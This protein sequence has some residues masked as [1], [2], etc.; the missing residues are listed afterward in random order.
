MS[1]KRSS[2]QLDVDAGGGGR[3]GAAGASF[4]KLGPLTWA[5][6]QHEVWARTI[7]DLATHPQGQLLLRQLGDNLGGGITF[8]TEFSGI[9]VPGMCL[10][11]IMDE[12]KHR[13]F[14]DRADVHYQSAGDI[15]PRCRGILAAWPP[16]QRARLVGGDILN[17]LPREILTKLH[18]MVSAHAE[19]LTDSFIA[20][21]VI[22]FLTSSCGPPSSLSESC[23]VSGKPCKL[24]EHSIWQRPLRILIAGLTCVDFTHA[25]SQKGLR[26]KSALPILTWIW[27]RQEGLEDL[28]IIEEAQCFIRKMLPTLVKHLGSIYE[29]DAVLACPSQFGWPMTRHRSFVRLTKKTLSIT[30]PL[31]TDQLDCFKRSVELSGDDLFVDTAPS[32]RSTARPAPKKQTFT[33]DPEVVVVTPKKKLKASAAA[34]SPGDS[35]SPS[36]TE[37]LS[38]SPLGSMEVVGE[39]YMPTLTDSERRHVIDQVTRSCKDEQATL[40][41]CNKTGKMSEPRRLCPSLTTSIKI[42]S[43]THRRHMSGREHLMALGIPHLPLQSSSSSSTTTSSGSSSSNPGVRSTVGLRLPVEVDAA[44]SKMS[45]HDLRVLA[46]NSINVNVM[47]IIL[48]FS[49]AS[50]APVVPRTDIE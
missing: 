28:I 17:K 26:G 21:E 27:S 38:P 42:W 8:L 20:D 37:G 40:F 4:S 36:A 6:A 24:L 15:D 2:E 18:N 43:S 16:G 47:A 39:R 12:M 30:A 45:E 34:G 22:G 46:G 32:T 41:V 3:V 5:E 23:Q 13:G 1:R 14:F 31:H 10:H 48:A 29:V 25:G 7:S 19:D 33:A 44:F 9:D 11:G 49:I 35:A 50:V